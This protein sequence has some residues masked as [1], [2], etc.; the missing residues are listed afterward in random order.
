MTEKD[1]E[2]TLKKEVDKRRMRLGAAGPEEL[3]KGGRQG[4]VGIITSRNIINLILASD[5]RLTALATSFHIYIM[6][7]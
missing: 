3:K 6:R 4:S 1:E 7:C 5:I 2:E